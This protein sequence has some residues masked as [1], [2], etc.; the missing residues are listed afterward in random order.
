MSS[1]SRVSFNRNSP[2]SIRELLKLLADNDED[3]R[4]TLILES[5]EKECVEIESVSGNL[6]VA[7]VNEDDFKFIDID[8]I[9]AVIVEA[10]DILES[11][12]KD[13]NRCSRC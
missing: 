1:R 5:G 10:R 8:C 4:V 11:I 3:V 13:K 12:F 7:T 2:C 6:L 9:C